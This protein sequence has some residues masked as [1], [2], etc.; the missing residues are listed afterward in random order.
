MLAGKNRSN[1]P[2]PI[3]TGEWY[4]HFMHLANPDGDFFVADADISREV[5]LLIESDFVDLFQE[6]NIPI[7]TDEIIN[8]I[9]DLKNGKCGGDDLLINELFIHGRDVLC[10]YMLHLFNFIF[11]SGIFPDMWRDGLLSPLYKRGNR[12]NPDNY[13]GI[14]LLSDLGKLF[15]RVLNNR[16]ESWAENY[17]IYVEAQNGFRKGRGT[18]DSVFVLHNVINEFMEK[19]NK[20]YTCFIDFSKAFDY[21]VHD[22]LWYKLLKSGIRGKIFNMLHSMYENIKTTVFCDG[23]KSEPFY[24]QLGVRQG[25]CLSPF[26]FAMYINDLEMYLSTSNSGI[27][28]SHVKMFLLLYADDIVIFADSAEELQSEINSLYSYCDRWKLKVNSSKSHVVVFKRG[29]INQSERWMYGNEEI[30]AVTKIPF[31]GL[32]FT[33]N[34]SFHQAQATLSD[35]ANKALFQLYRK[36]HPFSNLDVSTILDLFDKFVSPVLN[37]ACEVWGFHTALDI[38]RVHLNFCKRVLGVK[39]TT[40]NDFVYGILGRVPMNIIRHIRIVKYWLSIVGGKKSQIVSI[41]YNGTLSSLYNANVVNWASNVRD[42]LCTMGYGDIWVNQGATDPDGF[43][44]A[45]KCR[46]HD[47]YSQQWCGRLYVSPRAR[48]YR[49]IIPNRIFSDL[50]VTVTVK[51]HRIALTRLICSSHRLRVETGRWDRPVT[52]PQFRLCSICNV[53]DDEFHFLLEC[54][55]FTAHRKKLIRS[56]YWRRPSMYKCVELFH[57][58]NKKVLRNLAKYVYL[59]FNETTVS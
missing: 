37:Y 49:E 8:A 26:L 6:L 13:R 30:T 1:A 23:E 58:N 17:R 16:L 39:R 48:F 10:P 7:S 38:E 43:L 18:V 41:V 33:S 25:E 27:T 45:F 9:K 20:L 28:V 14:T 19:G 35:Q 4:N 46:L 47:V 11:D 57:T 36:L 22:N 40:Q 51:K 55:K 12:L 42:L 2:C 24:C 31:L 56:Y 3:S 21:V 5:R 15:T 59:S 54:M 34:G 52:P 29:R 53:V 32:L 44:A 50:L